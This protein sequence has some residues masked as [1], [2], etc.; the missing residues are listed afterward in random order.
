MCGVDEGLEIYRLG[1]DVRT[2]NTL[3]RTNIIKDGDKNGDG[4]GFFGFSYFKSFRCRTTRCD[5][6]RTEVVR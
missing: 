2:R 3:G 1:N 4:D 5:I 6:E